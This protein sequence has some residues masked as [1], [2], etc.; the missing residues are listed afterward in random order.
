M[1]DILEHL[2]LELK[3][4]K[5]DTNKLIDELANVIA[6]KYKLLKITAEERIVSKENAENEE[7][8]KLKN[9]IEQLKIGNRK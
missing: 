9:E 4:H 8:E 7:I 1:T 6:V 3:L 5:S 2:S